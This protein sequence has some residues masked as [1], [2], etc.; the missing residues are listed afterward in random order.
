MDHQMFLFLYILL[1]W[2]K[3]DFFPCFVCFMLFLSFR[4][5]SS[6]DAFW[7]RVEGLRSEECFF[8][9]PGVDLLVY[10]SS[11]IWLE[12][13]RH[14]VLVLF[15]VNSCSFAGSGV[16]AQDLLVYI[17]FWI[18]VALVVYW[19]ICSLLSTP[20]CTICFC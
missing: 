7:R 20:Y 12:F 3:F 13:W 16:V 18:L 5:T 1:L 14:C 10:V 15:R 19:N 17:F 9:K 2:C 11:G 6:L 4:K 8:F